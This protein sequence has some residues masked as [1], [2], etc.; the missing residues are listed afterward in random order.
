MPTRARAPVLEDTTIPGALLP[1]PSSAPLTVAVVPFTT[2]VVT[3]GAPVGAGV[4]T[5]I[6]VVVTSGSLRTVGVTAVFVLVASPVFASGLLAAVVAGL[7]VVLTAV[8]ACVVF[9]FV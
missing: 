5:V 9:R 1:L 2:S 8:P 3:S 7:I 4:T 6:S